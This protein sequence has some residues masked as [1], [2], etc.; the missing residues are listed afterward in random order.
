M[1]PDLFVL[2]MAACVVGVFV[3]AFVGGLVV[4]AWNALP[5]TT[6]I[7]GSETPMAA[8]I[9]PFVLVLVVILALGQLCHLALRLSQ[10]RPKRKSTL[11]GARVVKP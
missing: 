8:T 2:L 7:D 6:C 9:W 11:P 5:N 4:R 3:Y 1:K 10:W